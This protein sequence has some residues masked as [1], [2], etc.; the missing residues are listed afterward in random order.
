MLTVAK[1]ASGQAEHTEISSREH[2]FLAYQH[3]GVALWKEVS[4]QHV[5]CSSYKDKFLIFI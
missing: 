4:P 3:Q 1:V 5:Q 2:H